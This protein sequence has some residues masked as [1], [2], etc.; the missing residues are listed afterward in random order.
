MIQI[1]S[2]ICNVV[3]PHHWGA[4]NHVRLLVVLCGVA[5]A[6]T[7]SAQTLTGEA[8]VRALQHGGYVLVM[9]H[10]SSPREAPDVKTA[11]AGNVTRERQLDEKG[12]ATATS[13]GAALRALKIPIGDVLVSPTY[14]ARET[15]RLAQLPDPRP[16]P[17]LGDGGQSMQGISPEQTRWLKEKTSVFPEGTN[18]V[19]ITHAPNMTAAF[20]QW[21]SSLSD[22]ETIVLGPD[23]KG[24]TTLVARIKIE[25]W[26]QLTK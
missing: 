24:G 1:Q 19:L 18:A 22:G 13:M 10:A 9:R 15:A 26:S 25:D 11:D 17:E 12:R 20:P 14:R 7:A 23:G 6:H 3:Q 16:Q 21:T 8:L 5:L 2:V 4:M